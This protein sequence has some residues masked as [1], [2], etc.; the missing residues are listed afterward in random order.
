MKDLHA[1]LI[2]ALELV[3]GLAIVL[4]MYAG[5][6]V[7][8]DDV[9]Y[10][11]QAHMMLA[12]QYRL[13]GDFIADTFGHIA[14]LAL[15]FKLFGVSL[16]SAALPGVL[17]YLTLIILIF[18]IARE[19][20]GNRLA[21]LSALFGAASLLI[22]GYATRQLPDTLMGAIIALA[23]L[24]LIK[25]MRSN[26]W[27]TFLASGLVAGLAT[28]VRNDG[29]VFVL[30]FIVAFLI[31]SWFGKRKVSARESGCLVIGTAATLSIYF[32]MYLVYTH[33]PLFGI[34]AFQSVAGSRLSTPL[35]NNIN[36]AFAFLDPVPIS[37]F[38]NP[39]MYLYQY[40]VGPVILLSMLG[41]AVALFRRSRLGLLAVLNFGIFF[42]H[43]FGPY[44]LSSYSVLLTATR[45]FSTIL[46]PIS[47]L[48]A[49]SILLVYE[50]A[51]KKSEVYALL[52]SFVLIVYVLLPPLPLYSSFYAYNSQI[53]SLT[54]ADARMVSYIANNFR[55]GQITLYVLGEDMGLQEDMLQFLSG[56]NKNLSVISEDQ[57]ACA[58]ANLS[59]LAV[60]PPGSQQFLDRAKSWAG[61]NCSLSL[62]SNFTNGQ[63]TSILYRIKARS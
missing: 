48:A 15:S 27:R 19:L 25:A 63:N 47:I 39:Y 40:P 45:Y 20:G 34:S 31:A 17:E 16:F 42:Y 62:V 32:L 23:V 28:S 26:S 29:F 10:I 53:A 57:R 43:L 8:F 50:Y 11:N 7:L 6:Y 49:Y 18:L 58:P 56:Y 30:F 22:V 44:S 3:L 41:G 24:M 33:N 2:L 55:G 5:P 4:W 36:A 1:A 59:F 9:V 61:M 14:V 51:K 12:G 52:A 54:A 46:A 38:S 13:T 37:S 21:T 60:L 35:A